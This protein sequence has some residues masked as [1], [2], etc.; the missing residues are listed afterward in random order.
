MLTFVGADSVN[1]ELIERFAEAGDRMLDDPIRGRAGLH[2]LLCELDDPEALNSLRY[3]AALLFAYFA[4]EDPEQTTGEIAEMV[5]PVIAG[6]WGISDNA[7][8]EPLRIAARMI[9]SDF[10]SNLLD[11]LA[12]IGEPCAKVVTEA[13]IMWV[14]GMSVTLAHLDGESIDGGDPLRWWNGGVCR[15]HPLSRVIVGGAAR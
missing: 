4:T 15:P 1:R 10:A 11:P 7:G 14:L 12:Q 2:G 6:V 9:A 13:V 3:V 8:R 5:L